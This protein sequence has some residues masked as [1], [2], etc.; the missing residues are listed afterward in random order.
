MFDIFGPSKIGCRVIS[1]SVRFLGELRKE[2]V[3]RGEKPFEFFILFYQIVKEALEFA[4]SLGF[5]LLLKM[6]LVR[7][8]TLK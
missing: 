5:H 4:N 7:I 3:V 1:Q 8:S 2:G 6:L